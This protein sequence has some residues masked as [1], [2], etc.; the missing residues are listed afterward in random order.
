MDCPRLDAELVNDLYASLKRSARLL[1]RRAPA[2]IALDPTDGQPRIVANSGSPSVTVR[3][4]VAELTLFVNGRQAHAL[5]E[6]DGP[7]D[8]IASLRVA[9]FG[10]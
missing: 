9:S 5:V 10:V 4:P 2:G 7:A 8:A 6:F 3:G 1:T